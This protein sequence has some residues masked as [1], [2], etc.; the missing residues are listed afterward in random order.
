MK[1]L[2]KV[3]CITGASS[4]I[5]AASA[6]GFA[7][8]GCHLILGARR[9]DRLESLAPA[10][11]ELGASSVTCHHLDVQD[12][13]SVD[14]FYQQIK[15]EHKNIDVLINNAG[16]VL[17]LD[18]IAT[19]NLEDWQTVINT[20]VMGVLRMCRKVLPDMVEARAGHIIMTSSI[21]AHQVY[22]GGGP[23]CA[24]KHALKALTRTLKLELCGT[25]VRVS[26]VDPGMVETEFSLVRLGSAEKAKKVYEG[27]SP[28][29]AED[30]ADCIVFAASRP[31]HVNLDQ[32]IIMPS[33]QATVYKLNRKP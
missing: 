23:Y 27:L 22:E 9:L 11:R 20:N 12:S 5:G 26:S 2:G 32:I 30:I 33:D 18:T 16:L 28:L 1:L 3:V 19:G 10:L 29:Q 8:E 24:S 6:K 17:G 21:S 25:G 7:A 13:S 4:G 14:R 31:S 15:Q